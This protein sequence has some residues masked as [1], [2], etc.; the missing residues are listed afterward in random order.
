VNTVITTKVH[1][2]SADIEWNLVT[3]LAVGSVSVVCC[4]LAKVRVAAGTTSPST[5]SVMSS[6]MMWLRDMMMAS[7]RCVC[8]SR[9]YSYRTQGRGTFT[10]L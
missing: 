6:A 10:G 1:R 7:L 2:Y 3:Y 9:V 5:D 8:S 4:C